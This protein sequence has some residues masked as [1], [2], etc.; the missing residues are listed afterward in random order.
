MIEALKND[1]GSD[2]QFRAEVQFALGSIGGD[3]TGAIDELIESLGSEVEEVQISA[4]YALGAIG[5]GGQSGR[6]RV[7]ENLDS[8]DQYLALI[9]AWSLVRIQPGDKDLAAKATPLLAAALQHE[10]PQVRIESAIAP[11][12]D[13][14][15][16]K[17]AVPALEKAQAEGD[18]A[19]KA[20]ATAAFG[21]NQT[22]SVSSWPMLPASAKSKPHCETLHTARCVCT[23]MM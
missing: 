6:C 3:G 23:P 13:R 5:P 16:C 15:C 9:S 21:K 18:D 7:D 22:V 11:G 4:C 8:D 19:L 12:R 10:T 1:D 14:P 20:A 17:S 2:S